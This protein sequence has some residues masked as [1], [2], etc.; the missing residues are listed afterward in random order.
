MNRTL[1]LFFDEEAVSAA[2]EPY[3]GKFSAIDK[4]GQQVFPLCFYLSEKEIQYG[5][6]FQE[7][8][9]KGDPR[10]INRF[11]EHLLN[12]QASFR[13]AG[14]ERPFISLL[15]PL[16]RDI[17]EVY[18]AK[19]TTFG[20]DPEGF[21]TGIPISVAFSDS[22]VP[23][24]RK[25]IMAYLREQK[26]EPTADSGTEPPAALFVRNLLAAGQL[27]GERLTYAVV[28]AFASNLHVSVLQFSPAGKPQRVHFERFP[29]YGED[30][31]VGVLARYVVDEINSSRHLL[32]TEEEKNRE[33]Q[34]HFALAKKWNQKLLTTQRPYIHVQAAL[35]AMP[36]SPSN[37]TIRKKSIEELTR[38]HSQQLVRYM[39][40]CVQQVCDTEELARIFVLGDTLKNSQVLQ[41]FHRFGQDKLWVWGNEGRLEVLKGL[42]LN[43][44]EPQLT[45]PQHALSAEEPP[46]PTTHPKQQLA[47]FELPPAATLIFEWSPNRRVKAISRG[48]GQFEI[49]EHQHSKVI[50]GDHFV[51]EH[52][53]MGQP[54]MLKNVV[55]KGK[56]LGNYRSGAITH[57]ESS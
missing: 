33:Y 9:A 42:L 44:R 36:N 16:M 20:A 27:P 46:S 30:P 22:I 25:A 49:V 8:A 55:R 39:E 40:K 32:H 37:I 48:N 24:A 31:R 4:K 38:A 57:L 23:R 3:K 34:Q 15:E 2:V 26:L 6:S 51:L 12:K 10:A 21:D 50:T 7:A 13:L 43:S 52:I 53:Q 11:Y 29:G 35:S 47:A 28:E 17:L 41:A 5:A 19:L 1:A 14:Y 54:A 56:P 45:Q 18:E